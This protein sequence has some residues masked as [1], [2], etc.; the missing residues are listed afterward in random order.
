MIRFDKVHFIAHFFAGLANSDN[1]PVSDK[2]QSHSVY[3]GDVS[4][5]QKER[6]RDQSGENKQLVDDVE[7]Y[8]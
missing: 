2:R 5:N 6:S 4:A 1:E 7:N 3:N 8:V